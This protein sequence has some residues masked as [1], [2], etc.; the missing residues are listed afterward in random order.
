[1]NKPD[2]NWLEWLVFFVSLAIVVATIGYLVAAMRRTSER[3]P[4]LRVF[5]G[6]PVAGNAGHR[7]PV[8]VRNEGDITAEQVHV[9]VTLRNGTEE[10]ARAELVLAFV[11][12]RSQREGWVV[13]QRD[14]RC[15][16][17]E[18]RAVGYEV[19]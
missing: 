5:V 8:V 3:P 19:P 11:P 12:H 2:K 1:M 7:V 6:Q 16:A 17:V 9:E 15:C 18:G 4:D 10:I 13:F 14:P